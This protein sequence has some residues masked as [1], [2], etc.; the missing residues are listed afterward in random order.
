MSTKKWAQL[1]HK[2]LFKAFNKSIYE[3]YTLWHFSLVPFVITSLLYVYGHKRM[4]FVL[5]ESIKYGFFDV[6]MPIQMCGVVVYV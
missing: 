5:S 4:F 2:R 3:Q 1:D 6:S